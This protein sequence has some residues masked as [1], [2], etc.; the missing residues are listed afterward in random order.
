MKR[1]VEWYKRSTAEEIW[2]HIVLGS[3]GLFVALVCIVGSV[4]V[5]VRLFGW[6]AE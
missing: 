4:A 1:I 2:V 3:I 5:I 6:M